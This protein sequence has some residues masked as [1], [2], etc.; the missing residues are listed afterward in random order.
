MTGGTE[1]ATTHGPVAK[2][3]VNH[4]PLCTAYHS[5]GDT[6]MMGEGELNT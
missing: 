5:L 1:A 4:T 3:D 2:V 6:M